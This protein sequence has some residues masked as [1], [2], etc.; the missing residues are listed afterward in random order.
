MKY[1]SINKCFLSSGE[2]VATVYDH[3]PINY[4]YSE[5]K[6]ITCEVTLNTIHETAVN[7]QQ[8]AVKMLKQLTRNVPRAY[9]IKN[10]ALIDQ[11]HAIKL[12]NANIISITAI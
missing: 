8:E 3:A 2:V 11:L 9:R 10:K 6:E 1:Y 5:L 4:T 12:R 7:K